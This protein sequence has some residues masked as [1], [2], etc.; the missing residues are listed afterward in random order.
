MPSRPHETTNN[1]APERVVHRGGHPIVVILGHSQISVT[2]NTYAHVLPALA[3]AASDAMARAL[4]TDGE[5]NE[6]KMRVEKATRRLA[7]APIAS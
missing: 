7:C 5:R 2:A 1:D 6:G 4:F 3:Q